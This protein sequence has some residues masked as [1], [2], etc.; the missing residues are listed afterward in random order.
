MPAQSEDAMKDVQVLGVVGCGL[1]G[2]GIVEVSALAGFEVVAVKAT[3]GPVEGTA[4]R[5]EESMARA[6]AKGKLDGAA[7]DAARARMT[8]ASDLGALAR[9]DLVIECTAESLAGK[10]RMLADIER[11]MGPDAILAS[12][13]SSLPLADLASVLARPEQFLGMH[14]F[15]PAQIMKLVEV[16][17]I[18]DGAPLGDTRDGGTRETLEEVTQAARAFA[19]KIGKT[20]IVLSAEPGYVVN[21]LLVP[22]LCQAIE[23]LE[24]GVAAAADIDT[25][26]KLGCGHPLGPLALADLIGLDVVFAMAQ[27]LSTELRD[28][29]FRAPTLL[30]RLVLSGELGKKV[31][32]GI[33]DYRGKEPVENPSIRQ[34]VHALSA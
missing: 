30:R 28:K 34:S 18:R 23:M 22:Y 31:G 21:R 3:V 14:F 17:P 11:A 8:F 1:M 20:P 16:A 25:A 33:Y 29:R 2:A 15:S 7:R 24:G 19:E 27:S 26:M 12:N 13:T 32:V 4:R 9:C 6:V 5:V 10:K